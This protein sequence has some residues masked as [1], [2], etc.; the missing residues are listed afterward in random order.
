MY[1]VD[2]FKLAI[3]GQQEQIGYRTQ[4]DENYGKAEYLSADSNDRHWV[5]VPLLLKVEDDFA[6]RVIEGNQRDNEI[7]ERGKVEDSQVRVALETILGQHHLQAKVEA[8]ET[9]EAREDR[10]DDDGVGRLL[11]VSYALR[12][13]IRGHSMRDKVI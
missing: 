11:L 13:Y 4:M 12:Q 9:D 6:V 1:L 7:R 2:V 3:K 8:E 10:G 5:M